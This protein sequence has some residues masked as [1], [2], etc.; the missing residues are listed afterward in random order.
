MEYHYLMQILLTHASKFALLG[1]THKF[2]AFS[3]S[4]LT[5][6]KN[7]SNDYDINNNSYNNTKNN[8]NNDK[9]SSMTASVDDS[10]MTDDDT[11]TAGISSS[12]SIRKTANRLLKTKKF[13]AFSDAH[14]VHPYM[15]NRVII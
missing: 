14:I 13:V 4:T 1:N 9:P 8:N 6:L 12:I 2:E 10:K 15:G 3:T 7:I 5:I 11:A